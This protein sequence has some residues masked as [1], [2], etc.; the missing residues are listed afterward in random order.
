MEYDWP[1]NVRQ[2]RNIIERMM[3]MTSE[4]IL[5]RT[6]IPP[7]ICST[8]NCKK[9]AIHVPAIIPLKEALESVE[10]QLLEMAYNRHRT[11]RQM[12]KDLGIDASTIVRKAAKYGICRKDE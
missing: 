8:L 1:G 4:D 11:T 5:Q 10:K 3:V 9:G 2:L 7:H 6:D 12:A